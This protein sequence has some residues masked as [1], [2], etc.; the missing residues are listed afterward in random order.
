[1][2]TPQIALRKPNRSYLFR[3]FNKARAVANKGLM[4]KNSLKKALGLSMSEKNFSA[5]MEEYGTTDKH[6]NCNGFHFV[7]RCYHIYAV[8]MRVRANQW[9]DEYDLEVAQMAAELFD[10]IGIVE[11]QEI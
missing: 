5:K 3:A 9:Q 10:S 1:M 2:N 6:C 4:S 8:W 11:Y 7:G